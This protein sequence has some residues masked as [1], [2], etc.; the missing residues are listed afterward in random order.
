MALR[1]CDRKNHQ[2]YISRDAAH[3]LAVRKQ[4][5]E[6]EIKKRLVFPC[7]LQRQAPNLISNGSHLLKVPPVYEKVKS[8][9]DIYRYQH[10]QYSK[11]NVR[12]ETQR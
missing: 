6:K 10:M 9:K 12:A 1:F 8:L 11:N 5:R 2:D 7:S 4:E 3:P